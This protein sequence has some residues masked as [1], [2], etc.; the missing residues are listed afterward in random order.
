LRTTIVDI[1]RC[2][3]LSTATVDRVLNSRPGA[4]AGSRQ[5]V[6]EA[7]RKL[8]YLPTFDSV[9]LPSKP[10]HLAFIVPVSRNSF[11]AGLA[12]HIEDYASRL[13]VVASCTVRRLNGYSPEETNLVH[14]EKYC[15]PLVRLSANVDDLH[16]DEMPRWP[17]GL[18]LLRGA[19]RPLMCS[20]G[21]RFTGRHFGLQTV[22]SALRIRTST[23]PP[24]FE[25]LFRPTSPC[26]FGHTRQM[27]GAL[28]RAFHRLC[29]LDET[30]SPR[31]F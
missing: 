19:L 20:S 23:C 28:N 17:R 6:Y 21:L 8:N 29:P 11:L 22:G 26:G 2:A 15:S 25:H 1:A 16:G 31:P 30:D 7:A 27:L 3:G 12:K 4:S 14:A 24:M 9:T 5:R 18:K 10:A 13:P